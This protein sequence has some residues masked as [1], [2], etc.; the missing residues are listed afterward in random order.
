[1]ND[2]ELRA[3][4]LLVAL[5]ALG[6][7]SS[8][9]NDFFS[10]DLGGTPSGSGGA[11]PGGSGG[12]VQGGAGAAQQA[13][14]AGAQ[15]GGTGGTGQAGAGVAGSPVAGAGGTSFGGAGSGGGGAGA[16][17]GAGGRGT[18]SFSC[19]TLVCAE[20][21]QYCRRTLPPA[22]GG[23]EQSMCLPFSDSC[24]TVD[25]SCFCNERNPCGPGSTCMCSGD[26]GRV[27]VVCGGN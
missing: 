1:M 20:G 10:T 15:P 18:G 9:S 3:A 17:S 7:G 2:F 16:V 8:S 22:S 19:R 21:Q 25:C 4:Y 27:T 13:G 26:P 6:C 5:A 11:P 14:S 23:P 24:R 12:A